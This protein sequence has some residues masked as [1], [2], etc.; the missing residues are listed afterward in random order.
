MIHAKQI[1]IDDS[2]DELRTIAEF[3]ALHDGFPVGEKRFY[4]VLDVYLGSGTDKAVRLQGL[5]VRIDAGTITEAFMRFEPEIERNLG[6]AI[7]K[8]L[9]TRQK[10]PKEYGTWRAPGEPT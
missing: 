9:N 10:K 6:A 4:A 7:A 5:L 1:Y 2:G 8:E 3:T